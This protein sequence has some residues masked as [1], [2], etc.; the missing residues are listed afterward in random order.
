MEYPLVPLLTQSEESGQELPPEQAPEPTKR[1]FEE[2]DPYPDPPAPSQPGENPVQQLAELK[3]DLAALQQTMDTQRQQYKNAQA[4]I[5]RLTNNRRTPV[6]E[7]HGHYCQCL[8]ASKIITAIEKGA[9]A[10]KTKKAA[11]EEQIAV[12]E[13]AEQ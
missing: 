7:G 5:N 9:P 6:R 10:L 3:G 12:L 11:L 13:K 1:R 4:I 8:E 2:Q